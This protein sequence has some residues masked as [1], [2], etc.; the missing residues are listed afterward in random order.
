MLRQKVYGVLGVVAMATMMTAACAQSD[1]GITTAVKSK[2]AADDTVKA[3][4]ID[5]DTKDKVVTLRGDVGTAAARERAVELAR[6]TEGVRDVVD[7]L[8]LG[9][10][11]APTTGV[12][13]GDRKDADNDANLVGDAAITGAIKTK[14]LADSDVGGLKIDIDTTDGVVVLKGNVSSAAE[15]RKAVQ[16]ARGTDGVK[17]VKDQLKIVKDGK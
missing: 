7:V 15:K 6:S 3:Y 1:S 17:S 4:N 8:A 10:A 9:P 11:T 5:V 12:A 13:D 16:I 14:M 2:L